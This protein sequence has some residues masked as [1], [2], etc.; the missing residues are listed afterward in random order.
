[1]ASLYEINQ[2]ITACVD[3]ETGE[4]IDFEA[5]DALM[6][7]KEEK[8]ENVVCYIK[9]LLSDA[10]AIKGE[11]NA[12]AD[13]E[14]KCRAKA[15]QLKVWLAEALNGQK[16][17]TAKCAVSFRRSEQVDVTDLDSIPKELITETVT[18]KPDKTAIKALIKGGSEVPG[19][20]LIEN[21]NPQIK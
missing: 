15:E 13:R 14:A 9:N 11:K 3:E 19:C 5:L 12:L 4:I 8:I 17:A 10:E 21:L 20:R 1:M 2:A 7:Q 18:V 6:L 16:F